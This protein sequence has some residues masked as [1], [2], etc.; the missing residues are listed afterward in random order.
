[1]GDACEM[2]VAAELTLNGVPCIK[3]PENWPEYDPVAQPPGGKPVRISVKS[4]TFKTGSG[5]VKYRETDNFEWLAVVLLGEPKHGRRF[6]LIP[7]SRADALA[8][9]DGPNVKNP[10]ER[11]WHIDEVAEVLKDYEDN[12][13]LSPNGSSAR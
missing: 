8:R 3:V 5:H 11:F 6:F 13:S 12:F 4:R 1:M 7:R 9:R 10:R 2:L